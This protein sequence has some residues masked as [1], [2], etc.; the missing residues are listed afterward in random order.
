M[1]MTMTTDNLPPRVIAYLDRLVEAL[2]SSGFFA[3]NRVEERGPDAARA[4]FAGPALAAW[5]A[6]TID[7]GI[8]LDEAELSEKLGM[9]LAT[10]VL[11]ELRSDGIVDSIER[12]DGEEVFWLTE[13]GRSALEAAR[14][15]DK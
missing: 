6:G 14:R 5:Y 11:E 4:V 12:D 8:A 10:A 13:R 1:T 9:V 2:A 3:R 15:G 7:E